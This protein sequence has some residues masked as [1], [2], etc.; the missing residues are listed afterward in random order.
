MVTYGPWRTFSGIRQSEGV[1][2]DWLAGT[3]LGSFPT[4]GHAGAGLANYRLAQSFAAYMAGQFPWIDIDDRVCALAHAAEGENL[5]QFEWDPGECAPFTEPN[6]GFDLPGGLSTSTWSGFPLVAGSQSYWVGPPLYLD[7]AVFT[8]GVYFATGLITWKPFW[9]D[10]PPPF[11]N[12]SG[13]DQDVSLLALVQIPG[14]LEAVGAGIHPQVEYL[15]VDGEASIICD[16][17]Q[18]LGGDGL[19]VTG[20]T[21]EPTDFVTPYSALGASEMALTAG[22]S[23]SSAVAHYPN[24]QPGEVHYWDFGTDRVAAGTDP[25]ETANHVAEFR[26]VVDF[27]WQVRMR[28]PGHVVVRWRQRDD[29]L[30]ISFARRARGG[31]SVQMG[32]RNRGYR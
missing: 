15:R 10:L 5:V 21:R 16:A 18:T 22:S 4:Y 11:N 1:I 9:F 17:P 24:M 25:G 29:G 23:G 14:W 27:V 3:T 7:A 31:T 20:H 8:A 28:L 6:A 19:V 12:P 32:K 13:D 2:P 26:L 30:G